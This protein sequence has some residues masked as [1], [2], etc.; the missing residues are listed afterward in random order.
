MHVP[1]QS[2][3]SEVPGCLGILGTTPTLG[4]TS[5]ALSKESFYVIPSDS[6]ILDPEEKRGDLR[7]PAPSPPPP[8]GQTSPY[9][10]RVIDEYKQAADK[11]VLG[12]LKALSLSGDGTHP[13]QALRLWQRQGCYL[14]ITCAQYMQTSKQELRGNC[15]FGTS[16]FYAHLNPDGLALRVL[17]GRQSNM[18]TCH[19]VKTGLLRNF[20]SRHALHPTAAEV[21]EGCRGFSAQRISPQT[22]VDAGAV[23][24]F[25]QRSEVGSEALRLL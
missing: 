4:H 3:T 23:R 24:H 13:L 7:S 19:M 10:G 15:P 14:L 6:I 25:R 5:K 1:C 9:Q 21:D 18:T 17:R 2:H 12:Q 11:T 20:N 8:P 16:C 22:L